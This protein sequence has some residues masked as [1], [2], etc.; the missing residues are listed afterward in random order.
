LIET[1]A[2][3]EL[4]DHLG[5]EKGDPAGRGPGN[6]YNGTTPKTIKGE[7]GEIPLNMPRR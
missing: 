2:G 4:T 6:S 1:A 3:A 7:L 5:Y